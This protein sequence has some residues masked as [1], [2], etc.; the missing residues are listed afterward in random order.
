MEKRRRLQLHA[1]LI[2]LLQ[3]I[4]FH[5]INTDQFHESRDLLAKLLTRRWPHLMILINAGQ[6]HESRL[7][8]GNLFKDL[9]AKLLL[10]RR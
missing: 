4:N 3:Q 2:Y 5:L 1:N 8:P 7:L 6:L 9:L 10:T